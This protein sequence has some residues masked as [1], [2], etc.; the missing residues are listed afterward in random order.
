MDEVTISVRF[1]EGVSCQEADDK[2]PAVTRVITV[3]D[4]TLG[5]NAAIYE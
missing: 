4:S 1:V 3:S 2:I 5:C